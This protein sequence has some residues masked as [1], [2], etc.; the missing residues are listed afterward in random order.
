TMAANG[1]RAV[2]SLAETSTS[3]AVVPVTATS[4]PVAW[5]MAAGWP[6]R[7]GARG[8]GGGGGGGAGGVT[9]G[10]GGGGGRRICGLGDRGDTGKALQLRRDGVGLLTG[11]G[12]VHGGQ[13]EQ[14]AVVAGAEGVADGVEGDPLGGAGGGGAVVGQREGQLERWDGQHGQPQ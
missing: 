13:H 3:I 14:R 4:A 1:S 9:P 8:G 12:G 7:G 6:G 11:G 5:R 10:R 2:E